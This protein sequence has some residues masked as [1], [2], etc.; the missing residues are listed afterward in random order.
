MFASPLIAMGG[1][2]AGLGR[3]GVPVGDGRSPRSARRIGRGEGPAGS[4]GCRTIPRA[5]HPKFHAAERL[6]RRRH[7]ASCETTKV[8][9]GRHP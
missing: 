1:V 3:G 2:S 9:L 7:C 5:S 4:T 8:V 6:V